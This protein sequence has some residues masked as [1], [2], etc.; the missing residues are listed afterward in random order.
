MVLLQE[1]YN[2]IPA[3]WGRD[4]QSTVQKP[5]GNYPLPEVMFIFGLNLTGIVFPIFTADKII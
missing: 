2:K 3:G 4:E 1:R 5:T